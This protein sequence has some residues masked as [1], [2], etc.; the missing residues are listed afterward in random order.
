LKIEQI[1]VSQRRR[2]D[3]GDLAGL[4]ESIERYGLIHPIVID[5]SNNLVAGERRLRACQILGWKEIEV[6]PFG[7][8]SEAERREIE[9][10]ENLRHKD[11]TESEQ[12]RLMTQ[13]ADVVAEVL[14]EK[15]DEEASPLFNVNDRPAGPPAKPDSQEKVADYLGVS[16]STISRAR[17][18][19]TA[20][21]RH[22]EL[23]DKS[24]AEAL[25]EAKRLEE[26]TPKPVDTSKAWLKNL[27][28]FRDAFA[29]IEQGGGIGRIAQ[30][31]TIEG[32][33][34]ILDE[35]AY[36]QAEFQ[37]WVSVLA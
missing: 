4:A 29:E 16:Q 15:A 13:R 27:R 37:R 17:Q 3:L 1:I 33:K 26:P 24:Q 23:V 5:A 34:Q 14:R 30:S 31:W 22:P 2:E 28:M 7:E 25:R 12:S 6:R 36:I 18:H 9:L 32:R 19:V 10:E 11:L 21:E 20:V 8:L 35:I